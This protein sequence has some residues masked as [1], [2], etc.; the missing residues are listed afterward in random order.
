M[1]S[2][3]A[4]AKTAKPVRCSDWRG[5]RANVNQMAATRHQ[6]IVRPAESREQSNASLQ[7]LYRL[8][9]GKHRP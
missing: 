9:H 3:V 6:Q 7:A 5:P 4:A 1:M 8:W 2:T